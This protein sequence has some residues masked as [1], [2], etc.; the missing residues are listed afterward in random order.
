MAEAVHFVPHPRPPPRTDLLPRRTMPRGTIQHRKPGIIPGLQVKDPF[1]TDH[2][3]EDARQEAALQR[4]VFIGE[5]FLREVSPAEHLREQQEGTGVLG[6]TSKTVDFKANAKLTQNRLVLVPVKSTEPDQTTRPRAV[7][8]GRCPRRCPR[9]PTPDR[10]AGRVPAPRKPARS[11]PHPE[12]AGSGFP[13]AWML[14]KRYSLPSVVRHSS[15][16]PKIRR[17]RP[18]PGT[19]SLGSTA[20]RPCSV[21]LSRQALRPSH[22][23]YCWRPAEWLRPPLP[24]RP[25]SGS[26]P[27]ALSGGGGPCCSVFK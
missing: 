1:Q 17:S 26:S 13:E 21:A 3:H 16:P 23:H 27:P 24:L 25:D 15:P 12:Q 20:E 2:R 4:A 9:A 18:R 19:P 7:G 5:A 11:V 10:A 8:R 22:W 6:V 14:P